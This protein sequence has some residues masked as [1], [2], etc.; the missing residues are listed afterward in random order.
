ML[1]KRWLSML[2]LISL[3]FCLG[4]SQVSITF[5]QVEWGWAAVAQTVDSSIQQGLECYRS[6]DFRG[7]ISIW[8]EALNHRPTPEAQIIIFKYLA[9]AYSQ[10]GEFDR[11]IASLNRPID[12]YRKI[13]NRIQLGRM[14]TEQG[15][16]YSN[17][18]QQRQ[19]I[20]LLCGKQT[21]PNCDR[22]SALAI[23]RQQSDRQ[24][25]AAA[26]GTLGNVYRL[27]GDYEISLQLLKKSLTIAEKLKNSGY[28]I[29]AK[30][31][32]GNT[33]G[34]LAKR[35][36]RYAEFAANSG[37]RIA[38]DKFTKQGIEDDR[39]AIE[40]YE[41]TAIA[42]RQQNNPIEESRA[43]LNLATS[44]QRSFK[45]SPA[46][47]STLQQAFTLLD[48]IPD[49][50]D[51]TYGSIRLANLL[52]QSANDNSQLNPNVRCLPQIPAETVTL[53]ERAIAVSQRIGDGQAESF[54]LG[55]LGH[56][57]ECQQKFD[58]AIKF[59]QQ[60]Q[61]AAQQQDSRYLWD[62]QIGRILQSQ[63]KTKEAIAA[64][65]SSVKVLKEIRSNLAIAS[66]DFQFDFR[67]AVEPVYRELT[68]LQLQANSAIEDRDQKKGVSSLPFQGGANPK[69]KIQN[70]KSSDVNPESA[71]KT[72]DSLRLAELQN[73]L[74]EDCA[75]AVTEKPVGLIDDRTAILST[76]FLGDRVAVILTLP[77]SQPIVRWLP[78]ESQTLI[79]TV[80]D[81]RFKLEQRFDLANTYQE[82]AQRVYDWLIRPFDRDLQAAG[83]ETLVF[84]QDGILRSIP[85]TALYDGKGFLV[86]RYAIAN[87]L[88]LTLVDP[89]QLEPR[90]LRVLG[91]G[92]TKASS[93]TDPSTFFEPLSYVKTELNEIAKTIPGS[94]EFTDELFTI[95][96]LTA[97]LNQN[98]FPI[99]HLATHGKFGLD[100][101]DTYLVTGKQTDKYNEKLTM[102]RLY[103]I[104]Q[105]SKQEKP[106][107]LLTLTACETAVGSDRDALGLAGISIQAG[108]KSA[109]ASLWQVDDRAT[110]EVIGQFYQNLR[111]GMSRAKALRSAQK[112]W[113]QAHR[114]AT[115]HP[116]YW[117]ALT[118]VGN[119]L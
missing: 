104:L 40:Y 116:G 103:Q 49:S 82:P 35:D 58:P 29:A 93:V 75:I 12:Y 78:V 91:F 62:W 76:I 56:L 33:Y 68:A 16:A 44:Y 112:S 47:K 64:Y 96:R 98:T 108:A 38:K 11:A 67:D 101:Q 59:T 100:S 19:A 72:I 84:V 42:A 27:Q 97:E 17:L 13:G 118:L 21:E 22:E 107:E 83:I 60:A 23:A 70:P 7:A 53:L 34:N 81:L 79:A 66:R 18:G 113:L 9:R 77:K 10:V 71:L 73:Y 4:L 39:L 69:S 6:G 57:Y 51:K 26:L 1:K 86:E 114:G 30:N 111:R 54:A 5:K 105:T 102:N 25:E 89:T 110:A 90:S 48:R 106:P 92:L 115:N 99:I 50:R 119:W 41:Q 31:G 43:L 8:N 37:D 95:D 46:T 15:Q 87:T 24:G 65:E 61:F 20:A 36:Y 63:G 80:N 14:L 3:V 74:G 85:M 45:T 109:I 117:A 2:F 88:S 28:I 52:Q 94:K 55:R 32:L